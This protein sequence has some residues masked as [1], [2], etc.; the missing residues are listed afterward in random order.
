MTALEILF[1]VLKGV[2]SASGIFAA[3]FL[4]RAASVS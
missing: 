3:V 1:E 2:G 4:I